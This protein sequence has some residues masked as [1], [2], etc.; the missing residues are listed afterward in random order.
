MGSYVADFTGIST[1]SGSDEAK[2]SSTV[3]V[4]L[5]FASSGPLEVEIPVKSATYDPTTGH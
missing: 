1:S 5:H 3:T 2:W 4:E